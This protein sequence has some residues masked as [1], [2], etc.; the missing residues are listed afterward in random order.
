MEP[1]KLNVIV[2]GAGIA[3]LSA[4][5]VM[6]RAG[7]NVTVF[8]KSPF[9]HE[10]GFMIV[11]GWNATRV[12]ESFDFDF[13]KAR[14]VDSY[15][16][17]YTWASP[18]I[19]TL[20]TRLWIETFDGVTLEKKPSIS[21]KTDNILRSQTRTFYRPDLHTE[22]KR[23]AMNNPG[24]TP[25]TLL[26]GEVTRVDI[27]DGTVYLADG[28]SHSA[29][30]IIGA[31]GER[32]VVKTAFKDPDTLR[33][34][35]YRIFRC[36]VPTER[37]L[38]APGRAMLLMTRNTFS[39]FTKD[40]KTLFWFEGRDGLL[41]DLEAGYVPDEDDK[42]PELDPKKAKTK[43][44]RIFEDCHPHIIS[45]LQKAGRVSEWELSYF[46]TPHPHLVSHRALLIG[47]AAH[48]MF[49]TT[50]QG[51][52]QTIEDVGALSVLFSG[53]YTLSALEERMRVYER[54]RKERAATVASMSGIIFGREAEF[55]DRRGK[56]HRIWKTG[57]RN[58]EQHAAFLYDYDVMEESRKALDEET[59]T[60]ARL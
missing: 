52:S 38:D 39:I 40:N 33:K 13:S 10:A 14:S 45:S 31:D 59:L 51:G 48:S 23:L 17:S 8:E 9:K 58:G 47:D 57:I 43:M 7:H 42:L 50:G 30:L 4:A 54:V 49:P 35:K 2:V 24:G 28:T 16:V 37:L 29:N 11:M 32:S 41:Q 55:A 56:K 3:G 25:A 5:I 1:L 46:P 36:L 21:T 60:R 6:S 44:L 19:T 20:L 34:A 15:F 53:I 26:L 12:L 27:E 18:N 22:L